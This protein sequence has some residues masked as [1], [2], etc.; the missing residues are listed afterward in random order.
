MFLGEADIAEMLADLKQAGG[1]VDVA[2]A[3]TT[4]IGLRDNQAAQ[5]FEGEMPSLISNEES[6]H[7]QT[8]SLPGLTSG[9]ALTVNGVARVARECLP[10]GDGAMTRIMLGRP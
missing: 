7:V 1:T 2:L 5:L 4:V 9:S 10:Y 6:V 8:G 3:G